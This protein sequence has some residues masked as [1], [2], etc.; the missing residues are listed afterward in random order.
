MCTCTA[1]TPAP[2]TSRSVWACSHQLW[3]LT[4]CGQGRPY[5]PTSPQ[6]MRCWWLLGQWFMGR[7]TSCS[8]RGWKATWTRL[9]GQARKLV[10]KFT[11]ITKR[12]CVQVHV[13]IRRW[14]LYN[15]NEINLSKHSCKMEL[16]VRL[17]QLMQDLA[18]KL[19]KVHFV[20]IVHQS[21]TLKC[22]CLVL[23]VPQE[24]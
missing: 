15:W 10:I 24:Y 16:K 14:F 1:L 7:R 6:H 8:G 13:Y 23:H 11:W 20:D 5:T 17:H 3:V 4:W 12:P 21:M 9:L 22:L 19:L 18:V 2:S